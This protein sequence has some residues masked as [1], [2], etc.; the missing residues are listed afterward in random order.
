MRVALLFLA[1]SPAVPW[2]AM[3]LG[4]PT[5]PRQQHQSVFNVLDGVNSVLDHEM[6]LLLREAR[7]EV[8]TRRR[9]ASPS[10]AAMRTRAGVHDS[11]GGSEEG[12]E[13]T[14]QDGK[15]RQSSEEGAAEAGAAS[16]EDD[17]KAETNS[18][19]GD[20]EDVLE[21][22][23]DGAELPDTLPMGKDVTLR[24]MADAETKC[25]AAGGDVDVVNEVYKS[26]VPPE[27]FPI[28]KTMEN[29]TMYVAEWVMIN[30][31]MQGRTG[32][33]AAS[34]AALLKEANGVS[35]VN[36]DVLTFAFSKTGGGYCWR[37]GGDNPKVYCKL[38][39]GSACSSCQS[40]SSG[41]PEDVS[42]TVKMCRECNQKECKCK[43]GGQ[44]ERC[45]ATP[46]KANAIKT[47]YCRY[48]GGD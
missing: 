24:D 36:K 22:L 32:W 2:A 37:R 3:G 13:Q 8:G 19:E 7:R 14:E 31:Q 33:F 34:K 11:K 21:P 18:G 5:Q 4:H 41:V 39:S 10:F 15:Q 48:N 35:P 40:P 1:L 6:K 38:D 12:G 17:D 28:K 23:P 44:P 29:Y 20:G 26:R 46:L 25:V 30:E 27:A 43:C 47:T 42:F 16:S 9:S 45:V